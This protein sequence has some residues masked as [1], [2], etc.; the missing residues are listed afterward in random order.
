MTFVR[1]AQDQVE[2]PFHFGPAEVDGEENDFQAL[3]M[4]V[5]GGFDGQIDGAFDRPFVGVFD[6]VLAGRHFHD[7]PGDAAI[8]RALDVVHHAAGE[9]KDLRP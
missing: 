3:R 2:N 9:G 5:G 7:N 6:D 4:C 1:D 8:D